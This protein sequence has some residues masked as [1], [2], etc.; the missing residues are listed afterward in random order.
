M[1]PPFIGWVKSVVHGH[2]INL[3]NENE[4]DAMLLCSKP[5]KLQHDTPK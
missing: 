5:P 4:L 3:D 2:P 1:T